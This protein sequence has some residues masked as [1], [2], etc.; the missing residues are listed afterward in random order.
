MRSFH[1]YYEE[2]QLN[3]MSARRSFSRT[4]EKFAGKLNRPIAILT[5]FRGDVGASPEERLKLNRSANKKLE[6]KFKQ[7]GLSFYP[8]IGAGQ[9]P[10]PETGEVNAS[11]EE[12]YIAQPIS[13]DMSEED[14]VDIVKQLLYNPASELGVGPFAHTQWGAMVKLPSTPKAFLLHH[15][16]EKPSDPSGYD[17]ATQL[18]KSARPRRGSEMMVPWRDNQYKS[19]PDYF[20]TQMKSGPEASPS[21]LSDIDAERAGRRFTISKSRKF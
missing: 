20:F 3:E 11:S 16:D 12:S 1:E 9:E 18:G 15:G 14:F 17:Q 2:R 6:Q 5:A 7:H 8:V 10:N 19:G 4:L 13:A 21:M